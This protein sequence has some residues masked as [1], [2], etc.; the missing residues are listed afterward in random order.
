MLRSFLFYLV[1][2]APL[3]LA[4]AQLTKAA[5]PYTITASSRAAYLQARRR[6]TEPL[7]KDEKSIT[8][9]GKTLTLPL[10]NGKVRRLVDY[11]NPNNEVGIRKHSYEGKLVALPKYLI[12]LEQWEHSEK[13]LVDQQTGAVDTLKGSPELSPSHGKVAALENYWELGGANAAWLY[14]VTSGRVR[15]AFE[16]PLPEHI[17]YSLVW[18]NDRSFILRLFPIA[19]AGQVKKQPSYETDS[20]GKY[21]FTYWLVQLR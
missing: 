16:L 21:K 8:K 13:L 9:R 6:P 12:H 10:S 3:S 17:P 19:T 14:K 4:H 7:L 5:R 1:L 18:V 15:Q 2:L 11:D 20:D